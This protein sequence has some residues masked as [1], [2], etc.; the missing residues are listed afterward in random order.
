[1]ASRCRHGRLVV[2]G[3]SVRAVRVV[4]RAGMVGVSAYILADTFFIAKGVGRISPRRL[5]SPPCCTLGAA[6]HGPC[7]GHRRGKL[8]SRCA[9]A[10]DRIGAN[11]V[12]TRRSLW[13]ALPRRCCSAVVE[14]F[15]A[16]LSSLWGGRG[17]ASADRDVPAHHLRVSAPLFLLNNVLLP[18]VRNDGSP[19]LAMVAAL[20]GASGNIALDALFIFGFGWVMFGAA[21]ATG[22]APPEH[23]GVLLI[24]FPGSAPTRFRPVRLHL[25][26]ARGHTAALGFLVVRG[27]AVGRAGFAGAEL[28]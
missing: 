22:F 5:T 2:D 25:S 14:A 19:Q 1:M 4:Q 27:R 13:R 15:G 21:F 7:A 12:T 17:H 28:W 8:S 18:F 9:P 10:R 23:G 24:H 20:V 6:G 3:A 11:R 16:P 26:A